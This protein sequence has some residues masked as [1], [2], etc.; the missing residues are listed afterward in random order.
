MVNLMGPVP[1][2]EEHQ[3]SYIVSLQY[4]RILFPS[5]KPPSRAGGL[6]VV[7]V[8]GWCSK[9]IFE[10]PRDCTCGRSYHPKCAS[11]IGRCVYCGAELVPLI[12]PE[13]EETLAG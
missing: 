2:D 13:P 7:S 6:T 4:M 12:L 3:G 1:G 8:C 9:E 11:T 5:T 10:E